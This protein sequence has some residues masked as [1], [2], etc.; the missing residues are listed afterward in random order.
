MMF[1]KFRTVFRGLLQS[2]AFSIVCILTLALG[3]GANTAMFSVIDSLLL[4][5]LPFSHSEQ[6]VRLVVSNPKRGMGGGAG[7]SLGA[8]EYY[9]DHSHAFTDV[10][11]YDWESL[12]ITGG[13]EPEELRAS[14]VSFNYFRTL[15]TEPLLGRNFLP[16][17]D[18][19]GGKPVAIL[20]QALWQ[21]RFAGDM[22]IVGQIFLL[23]DTAYTVIGVMPAGFEMPT[24]D[25]TLWVTNLS[26]FTTF[27]PQQ[28]RGGAG[29]LQLLARLRPGA[30]IAGATA[31]WRFS[32]AST[33]A[34]IPA[35][36]MPI[37]M[38]AWTRFL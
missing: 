38:R 34:M 11:A 28:I 4:R 24:P 6:L 32:S 31:S 20:S 37:P 13:K 9:R 22:N 2:P 25:V 7:I 16:E 8:Y 15:E 14:R 3:I 33:A 26:G 17:E 36:P 21:R 35:A 29:Y 27:T 30:T 5:R 10:A 23:D 18:Q 1:P 12:N 19:P